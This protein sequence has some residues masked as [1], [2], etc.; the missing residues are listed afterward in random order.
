VDVGF[1]RCD[2]RRGC[3]DWGRR[4]G[5]DFSGTALHLTA[6]QRQELETA[7]AGKALPGRRRRWR[8]VFVARA[9][10]STGFGPSASHRMEAIGTMTSCYGTPNA[11]LA[12]ERVSSSVLFRECSRRTCLPSKT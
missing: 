2:G 9:Y 1:G 5:Q 6:A 11:V 3:H 4:R 7:A 8:A 12:L 10:S